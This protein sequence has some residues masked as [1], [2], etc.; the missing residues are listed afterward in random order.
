MHGATNAEF[1]GDVTCTITRS[2]AARTR[3]YSSFSSGVE[4]AS[5]TTTLFART[6]LVLGKVIGTSTDPNAVVTLTIPVWP[7]VA[8]ESSMRIL[9]SVLR[10]AVISTSGMS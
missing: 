5:C 6:T 4:I 1:V 9:S 3:Q 2:A 8:A 10:T 7:Q